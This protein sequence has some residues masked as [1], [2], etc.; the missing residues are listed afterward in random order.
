MTAKLIITSTREFA[1][2]AAARRHVEMMQ[3]L[4]HLPPDVAREIVETG[5][6]I[7]DSGDAQSRYEI[8]SV[9]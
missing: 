5:D 6:G 4:G 8:V 9:L 7:W 1:T 2:K 3:S